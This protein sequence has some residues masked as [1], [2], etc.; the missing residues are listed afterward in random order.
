MVR[1]MSRDPRD[2]SSKK[3]WVRLGYDRR[4]WI[5]CMETFP[6]GLDRD[7]WAAG[8]AREWWD[9]S[10]LEHSPADVARLAAVLA[11]IHRSTF[12]HIA[13]HLAFAHLP[14]PRLMPLPIFLGVFESG[15]ERDERLRLLTRA[16][17]QNAVEPPVVD[18]FSTGKL[19]TGLRTLRYLHLDDGAL[20]AAL[21]YAWRSDEYETDVHLWTSTEDLARLERAMPD[22]DEFARTITVVSREGLIEM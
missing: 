20:Y 13:C 18:E 1:Q 22:I 7:S 12:G 5:P 14:D 6:D 4:L 10:G 17:D 8:F 9:G 16:D 3:G 15:G 2:P 21:N 11:E 19:G